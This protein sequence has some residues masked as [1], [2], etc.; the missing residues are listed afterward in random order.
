MI[1]LGPAGAGADAL[2]GLEFIKS[3]GLDACELEFTH[4]VRMGEAKARRISILN[5]SLGLELSVHAPYFINL[6]SDDPEKVKASRKRIL[7]SARLASIMGARHVVFHAGFLMGRDEDETYPIIK[8]E[9]ILLLKHVHEEKLGIILAPETTGKASQFGSLEVLLRMRSETG[10][11]LCVDFAHLYA[12]AQGKIDY[13]RVFDML[14]PLE[15]IHSHFSG[16]EF[17]PKGER[18]HI[19]MDPGFFLP[20]AREIKQRKPDMTIISESPITWEDSLKMKSI[21]ADL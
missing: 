7:D 16:I 5:Q 1:R 2:A 4:G 21:L 13:G 14:K 17:G 11:G 12:R 9:I 19:M 20:L 3:Q 10:C 6:A 18:R 8:K 15:H